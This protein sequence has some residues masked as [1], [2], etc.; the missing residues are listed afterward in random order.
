MKNAD[1][2]NMKSAV[3][4]SRYHVMNIT[5]FLPLHELGLQIRSLIQIFQNLPSH[6]LLV[7]VFPFRSPVG[8]PVR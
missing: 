4:I 6:L 8:H 3:V 5:S 2:Y 7:H 1:D